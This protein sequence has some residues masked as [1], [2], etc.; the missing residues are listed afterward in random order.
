MRGSHRRQPFTRSLRR[1]SASEV[2]HGL[3]AL[4]AGWNFRGPVAL[5]EKMWRLIAVLAVTVQVLVLASPAAASCAPRA[6]TPENAARAELVVYGTVTDTSTGALTL[7]VDRVLKGQ[8]GGSVRVFV[9]PGRGGSVT[10]V[11]YPDIGARANVGSDHVLYV[12]RAA[13]GQ[14]ETNACVGSHPGP[15]DPSEATFFGLAATGAPSAISTPSA[16]TTP[17]VE[18]VVPAPA[19]ATAG[20]W[21]ALVIAMI[22]ISFATL[23]IARRRRS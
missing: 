4:G 21:A 23:S 3:S 1:T 12:L 8:V 19:D 5:P 22:V 17:G 15:P 2:S 10:S 11:D 13:D 9:G 16:A 20:P 7:R 6:A 14:L 18:P